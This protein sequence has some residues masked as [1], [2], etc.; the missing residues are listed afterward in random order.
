MLHNHRHS[1]GARA[2][3]AGST[4]RDLAVRACLRVAAIHLADFKVTKES[5]SDDD[6]DDD[7][8]GDDDDEDDDDD[9][10]NVGE[11]EKRV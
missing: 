7:D 1:D 9:N 11:A 3:A 2:R 4:Q 6:D 5:F 10:A 8:D